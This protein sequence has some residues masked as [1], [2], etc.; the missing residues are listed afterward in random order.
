M[1]DLAER[2]AALRAEHLGVTSP[3]PIAPNVAK[4]S[5]V[6]QMLT[7]KRFTPE[8]LSAFGPSADSIRRRFKNET[9]GVTRL[10]GPGGRGT[11]SYITMW[12]SESAVL[13]VLGEAFFA[14]PS[15]YQRGS[16]FKR[17]D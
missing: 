3:P 7:E 4:G 1:K 14:S 6:E 11:R 15:S 9:E 2:Q 16:R 13:R 12:I 8:Q 10:P 5:P 17:R